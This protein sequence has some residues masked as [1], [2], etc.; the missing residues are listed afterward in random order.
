[1]LTAKLA[2]EAIL[3]G[4]VSKAEI[5]LLPFAG[6]D[7]IQ[8]DYVQGGVAQVRA[9]DEEPDQPRHMCYILTGF[10]AALASIR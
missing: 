8:I 1:M 9:P 7:G 4:K 2:V 5:K 6:A 10:A 3:D